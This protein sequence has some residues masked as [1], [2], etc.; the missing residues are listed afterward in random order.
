MFRKIIIFLL[1]NI[2]VLSLFGNNKV[3]ISQGILDL[4]GEK[5]ENFN[6]ISFTGEWEFYWQKLLIHQDF[7][8]DSNLKMTC[9]E[10][11]PSIWKTIEIDGEPL[12]AHGYATYRIK[13]L[14]D[15]VG[16]DF[17]IRVASI[18]SA[19]KVFIDDDL[20]IYG[21]EVGTSLEDSEPGY[22]TG[23]V[24]F[25][26]KN[27]DFDI[28][29]QVSNFRYSK[30]GLWNNI[31]SIGK[32]GKVI[33]SW[34]KKIELRTFMLGSILIIAF[35]FFGLYMLNK[36]LKSAIYFSLFCLN[37]ALRSVL[38]N[39]L[40]ILKIFPEFNWSLIV[41]LEY[42]SLPFGSIV[43]IL[44]IADLF[45]YANKWI[46]KGIIIFN[47]L[48]I[49]LLFVT[50]VNFFTG[51]LLIYQVALLITGVYSFY[52]VG[53]GLF[54]KERIAYILIV[55]LAIL[56]G[57]VVNDVLY[58]NKVINTAFLTTFG[59]MFFILVQAYLLSYRFFQMFHKTE[60]LAK[61][62]ETINMNLEQTVVER[63]QEIQDQND[64]LLEQNDEITAQRDNIELQNHE[65]KKQK[66]V[67]TDSINYAQR[68]QRAI[69]PSQ[70]I[71]SGH[72]SDHF[73]IY[74]PKD[75]VSGD[76]YW[77]T[78]KENKLIIVAA[79]CTGHGVP[80]AFMSMLGMA[81]L[82]EI[83]KITKVD[84]AS[85][86]LEFLR[87][88]VKQSLRQYDVDSLQKEGMDLALCIYDP[89]AKVLEYSGA[90]NPL[91]LIRDKELQIFKGDRQPASVHLKEKPFTDKK[92]DVSPND[93][94]YIFSDGFSDQ[95][96][97]D[98]RQK[99][100]TK[101]FQK[102]LVDI[103]EKPMSA[104]KTLLEEELQ[105]WKGDYPQIDDILVIGFRLL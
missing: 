55:G 58:V 17:G 11:V 99:Y 13:V 80:G 32:A 35:Y 16:E 14:T 15:N 90:Y 104:Q 19:C 60:M 81:F 68:I 105:K 64:I 98:R 92:V 57:S 18:A 27:T 40:F 21:G 2:L 33:R 6:E 66:Q 10:K 94:F 75:I 43:F 25:K 39:E 49:L 50:P 70:N 79:D 51:Q 63:T 9:F 28:I 88:K 48:L 44:F 62:L 23:V 69:L 59:F 82:A 3:T 12:P 78:K 89:D 29:V 37:I 96:G 61:N 74:K 1:F 91:Y 67:I 56:I 93:T 85:Q 46:I 76:F 97:G 30:G 38:I 84:S 100:M 24:F 20:L 41:R 83:S 95:V 31:N 26:N 52:L 86:M 65:L 72:L 73:I 47:S 34:G 45:R 22:T 71:L 42:L 54:N 8:N 103:H 77:F 53:R 4:R 101:N 5:F 102:L 87:E 36:N 7:K